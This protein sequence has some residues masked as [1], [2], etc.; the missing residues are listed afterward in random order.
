MRASSVAYA[1]AEDHPVCLA[2]SVSE[3]KVCRVSK[4]IGTNATFQPGADT[5]FY[6][7]NCHCSF[8]KNYPCLNRPVIDSVVD[9][10]VLAMV[11][12]M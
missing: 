7:L 3:K 8:R 9:G 11:A 6:Y 5:W 12:C 4:A 10:F 1:N 2:V